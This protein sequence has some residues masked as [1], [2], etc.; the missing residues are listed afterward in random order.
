[1]LSECLEFDV[2][3]EEFRKEFSDFDLLQ[4][5]LVSSLDGLSP[6]HSTDSGV[7]TI[8]DELLDVENIR[9]DEFLFDKESF[10]PLPDPLELSKSGALQTSLNKKFD[11]LKK[12]KD[13]DDGEVNNR[14]FVDLAT[15]VGN[16]HCYTKYVEEIRKGS[17]EMKVCLK[18]EEKPCEKSIES[19]HSSYTTVK[20]SPTEKSSSLPSPKE[21]K[22]Y[23]PTSK[24][25]ERCNN[26]NALMA[27]LNR[28]RK[29]RY[30]DNLESEVKLLRKENKEFANENKE[31]KIQFEKCREEIAYLKGV[32]AN[33]SMLSS[34]IK[35]V[36]SVPS[37][38]FS[39]TVDTEGIREENFDNGT[40]LNVENT[41]AVCFEKTANSRKRKGNERSIHVMKKQKSLQVSSDE[42]RGI[43]L[44]V[45]KE[46]VSI[47]F[48]HHCST[49][50]KMMK[51]V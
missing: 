5:D 30:L 32:I 45:N 13:T 12:T 18:I 42:K 6:S 24:E 7:D 23:N 15:V 51:K 22:N 9:S 16:D 36:S 29:K 50:A 3:L 43:C 41:S 17:D 19:S 48:C 20:K 27:R 4:S 8:L 38:N 1:M 44:H 33:E 35:A 10:S 11:D 37:I 47:E 2:E 25:S 26:K 34:V 21:I 46:N 40:D 49:H 31:L 28:E 14:G 39:G